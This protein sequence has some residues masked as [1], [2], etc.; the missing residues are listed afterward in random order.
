M[1]DKPDYS[2]KFHRLMEENVAEV[3]PAL[4][5]GESWI[6]EKITNAAKRYGISENKI[7]DALRECAV[8]RFYFAK[9]PQ[10]QRMHE[11]TAAEFICDINGVEEFMCG[12][13]R[14][15]DAIY[16]AGGKVMS[17]EELHD[18]QSTDKQ[19][20][21]SKSVDFIWRFNGRRFYAYHKFTELAGG[22]QGNQGNDAKTFLRECVRT[23]E[24]ECV[25]IALCDGAFYQRRDRIMR[26]T[27]MEGL[28]DIAAN[29]KYKNVFAMTTCE[30]PMFLIGYNA[31]NS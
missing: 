20:T 6:L 31:D 27:K 13:T 1:S 8:L 7:C 29:A 25:F 23:E 16:I 15:E 9:D 26:K 3:I 4:D 30:L 28:R 22:A 19:S 18:L 17:E 10:K 14:G 5:K 2:G 21:H 11:K 24:P 12:S